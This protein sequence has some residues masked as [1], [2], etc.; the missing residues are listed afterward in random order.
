MS[1]ALKVFTQETKHQAYLETTCGEV[2]LSIEATV[3]TPR[4]S[5]TNIAG[6]I[7]VRDCLEFLTPKEFSFAAQMYAFKYDKPSPKQLK[8]LTKLLQDNKNIAI[9]TVVLDSTNFNLA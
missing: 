7:L 3:E 4:L 1:K 8:W 5:H 6:Y 9:E 2:A